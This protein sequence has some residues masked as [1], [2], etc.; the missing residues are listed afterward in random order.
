[1]EFYVGD[2]P[3]WTDLKRQ[4]GIGEPTP[5]IIGADIS[6]TDGRKRVCARGNLPKLKP[7]IISSLNFV[8]FGPVYVLKLYGDTGKRFVGKGA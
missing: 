6:T 7:A 5:A 8:S 1:V 4:L 3:I 2:G